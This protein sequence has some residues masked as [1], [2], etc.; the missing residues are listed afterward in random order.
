MP[1]LPGLSDKHN[2]VEESVDEVVQGKC[3]F[4]LDLFLS[5]N[6]KTTA[7]CGLLGSCFPGTF[8]NM[9]ILIKRELNQQSTITL[10]NTFY[11]RNISWN[12]MNWDSATCIT[13]YTDYYQRLTLKSCLTNLEKTPQNRS[14]QLPAPYK[15]V[16]D[17]LK[18]NWQR[19]NHWTTDNLTRKNACYDETMTNNITAWRDT[20][21]FDSDDDCRSGC[22][23][24]VTVNNSP[25]QNYDYPDDHAPPT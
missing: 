24:S 20:T 23:T 25:I 2:L 14:Q 18:Q 6:V 8:D 5:L 21:H 22:E 13:C 19:Q 15:R 4:F 3:Y 9:C 12:Q 1:E 11:R 16:I 17:G 10:L 7:K